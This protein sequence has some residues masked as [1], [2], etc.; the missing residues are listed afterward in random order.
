MRGENTVPSVLLPPRNHTWSQD[1]MMVQFTDAKI[2]PI[3]LLALRGQTWLS[4]IG[5]RYRF[6]CNNCTLL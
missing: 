4:C 1:L 3:K 2:C 6:D 5:A